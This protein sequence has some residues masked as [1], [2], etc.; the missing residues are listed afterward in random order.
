VKGK[1]TKN[2]GILKIPRWTSVTQYQVT[3]ALT[4]VPRRPEP[5]PTSISTKGRCR[6]AVQRGE[7][8]A[9]FD[10]AVNAWA[11]EALELGMRFL[12]LDEPLLGHVEALGYR[13]GIIAKA[14]YP[15]LP[16]DVPALDFSG[17]P[18]FTRADA[19]DELITALCRALD[20][21]SAIRR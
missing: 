5:I 4:R 11:H 10:E 19:P 8:D 21:T 18:V 2:A 1:R 6:A 16:A 7:I 14:D 3:A 15:A 17:W 12:P 9:I 13:H 20:S